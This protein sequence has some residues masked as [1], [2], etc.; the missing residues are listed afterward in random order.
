MSR[1]ASGASAAELD[2]Q[3]ELEAEPALDPEPEPEPEPEPDP[4]PE[5]VSET[6]SIFNISK[7]FSNH[8]ASVPNDKIITKRKGFRASVFEPRSSSFRTMSKERGG[9]L[10]KRTQSLPHRWQRRWFRLKGHYLSYYPSKEEARL[11]ACIDMNSVISVT[12]SRKYPTSFTLLFSN[13]R[14]YHLRCLGRDDANAWIGALDSFIRE[15][16]ESHGSAVY[17]A[18]S[19]DEQEKV[20]SSAEPEI[21]SAREG[22]VSHNLR[23]PFEYPTMTE[24]ELEIEAHNLMKFD[25][26]GSA[27][28]SE[29]V[30]RLDAL[31]AEMARRSTLE[32]VQSQDMNE[33][34][35]A[36][37]DTGPEQ[38]KETDEENTVI[39]EEKDVEDEGAA[40]I[41]CDDPEEIERTSEQN[42]LFVEE[43]NDAKNENTA[44]TSEI[45][46]EVMACASSLKDIVDTASLSA[47]TTPL[48]SQDST[49][50]PA[51]SL[52]WAN[53]VQNSAQK[54]NRCIS[55]S[56]IPYDALNDAQQI[57]R[58]ISL[59]VESL[60][61]AADISREDSLAGDLE[62]A[63]EE[64][65]KAQHMA[66]GLFSWAIENAKKSLDAIQLSR[67]EGLRSEETEALQNLLEASRM[68]SAFRHISLATSPSAARVTS[69]QS[70]TV[71]PPYLE[72][73]T[74]RL[75]EIIKKQ[76][77][78]T[79]P[80][81]KTSP[82]LN[83]VNK[84]NAISSLVDVR[85]QSATPER[86]RV[87]F[88][89]TVATTV[90]ERAPERDALW[91]DVSPIRP[92]AAPRFPPHLTST[93][94]SNRAS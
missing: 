42:D 22:S 32:D 29:I 23:D 14:K 63:K 87:K 69:S 44:N 45:C 37:V 84:L 93:R 57:A 58:S 79:K 11:L 94:F 73:C 89:P 50:Y 66:S 10:E 80:K 6:P 13:E 21:G 47:N 35:S 67:N 78:K 85:F 26:R 46:A 1:Q 31:Q 88:S 54:L 68:A 28:Y 76:K 17:E 62:D 65:V 39:E 72:R 5:P 70:P 75:D 41:S 24:N 55:A 91:P 71:T 30:H 38:K 56:P 27:D 4:E 64:L 25:S 90:Y 2:A 8:D 9:Y 77:E 18:R 86:K 82:N 12:P 34:D 40:N 43:K 36:A 61:E 16:H 83:Y 3:H 7:K 60:A 74:R 15:S 33:E 48:S 20:E 52:Y 51:D 53:Q 81:S 19:Q 92:A 59:A 49:P